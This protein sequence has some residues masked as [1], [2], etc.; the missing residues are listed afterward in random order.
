[1]F[2]DNNQSSSNDI[3]KSWLD[4]PIFSSPVFSLEKLIFAIIIL[5]AIFTRLYLLEP[6]IMSHDETSHTY[7]SW[8]FYKG[9]GYAHDPVTHGPLQFHLVALSYFLFGDSDTSARIPAAFF[10]IATVAFMWAYRQYLG[11]AG[12]LLA[13]L[14]LTISPYMLY[15]GRY[16]RNE[17]Y[18]AFFG[19]VM[20]WSILRY[21]DTAKNKYLY[22][23]TAVTVLHFCTKE[24]SFI[25]SAQALMFL[26][27]YLVYRLIRRNLKKSKGRSYFLLALIIS[28]FLLLVGV[29]IKMLGRTTTVIEQPK[30]PIFA[31]IP[32]YIPVIIMIL[33]L[34]GLFVAIY[35]A[36]SGFGL[37]RI[38]QEGSFDLLMLL[39]TFV[40]PQLS[41]FGINF[42]GWKVPVNATE[43]RALTI[44]DL[45]HMAIIVVPIII[46]SII[47]GLWWNKRQWLINAGIWYV[48]YIV[49]YTSLFTN[50]EAGFFTGFVGSMGYLLGHAGGN[51]GGTPLFY[52]V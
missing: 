33:G 8:L 15:Y 1:M 31:S 6:R 20:L 30:Y 37:Y 22:I 44:V 36:I 40:L 32:A 25:Y 34:I 21:M 19:V 48:I 18:V 50:V 47:L 41:A 12:A 4:H 11:R 46:I 16:V 14:F 10:S 42:V 23:F 29:I 7:F 52:H 51:R 17:A 13:A 49:L 45:S 27:F 38:R 3:K 24:T 35:F 9:N 5:L 26:A 39:G 43:V 2:M 28:L